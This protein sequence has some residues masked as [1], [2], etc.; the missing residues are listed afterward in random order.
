MSCT[1]TA[2]EALQVHVKLAC[3]PRATWCESCQVVQ[4]NPQS[5][6]ISHISQLEKSKYMALLTTIQNIS[7][8]AC[9]CVCVCVCGDQ[10]FLSTLGVGGHTPQVRSIECCAFAEPTILACSILKS[11]QEV[12]KAVMQ[13]QFH[14]YSLLKH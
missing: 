9:V 12:R 14:L 13:F 3:E 10:C 11:M 6:S 2:Q 1:V 5:F 8:C 4:F 7:L